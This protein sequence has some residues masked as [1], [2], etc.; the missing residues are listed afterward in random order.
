MKKGTSVEA[1]TPRGTIKTGKY[2]TTE[3]GAK[4][5]WFVIKPHE[6]GAPTF[7]ARPSMVTA[8]AG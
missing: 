2:Q 8:V 6:K 4:G 7:K 5:Q 3:T 1:R